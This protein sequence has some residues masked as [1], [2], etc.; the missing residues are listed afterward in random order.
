M[1]NF[2]ISFRRSSRYTNFSIK[3]FFTLVETNIYYEENLKIFLLYLMGSHS[4]L[5]PPVRKKRGV[6]VRQRRIFQLGS[7]FI[8][9]GC[10]PALS[11]F[12]SPT[13]YISF[14]WELNSLLMT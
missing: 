7:S 4:E 1:D 10:F 2:R 12:P 11:T 14:S 5:D 6:G 13:A 8:S 3:F 9:L